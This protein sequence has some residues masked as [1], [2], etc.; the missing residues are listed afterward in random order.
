MPKA[1]SDYI[2]D[3]KNGRRPQTD[4]IKCLLEELEQRSAQTNFSEVTYTARAV[5]LK[6]KLKKKGVEV[7]RDVVGRT[8]RAFLIYSRLKEEKHYR[9]LGEKGSTPGRRYLLTLSK[10]KIK[11]LNDILSQDSK[12]F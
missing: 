12:I 4:V 8:I 5:D 3:L 7:K 10:D 11:E 9:F 2:E 1:T 6:E